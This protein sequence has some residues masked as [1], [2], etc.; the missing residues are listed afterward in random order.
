[1]GTVI[2]TASPRCFGYRGLLK[3]DTVI[4]YDS[5][6]IANGHIEYYA[7]S[8]KTLPNGIYTTPEELRENTQMLQIST[9]YRTCVSAA[10]YG[11]D[12][13]YKSKTL[14]LIEDFENDMFDMLFRHDS[15]PST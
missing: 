9:K 7:N 5:L 2:G 13:Y 15:D 14:H 3:K 11:M 8:I 1:M 4:A 10:E 12:M 6:I